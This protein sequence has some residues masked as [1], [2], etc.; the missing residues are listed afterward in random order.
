MRF[1]EFPD[2]SL[3][4]SFFP[5]SSCIWWRGRCY[6]RQ[7][8]RLWFIACIPTFDERSVRNAICFFKKANDSLDNSG[9]LCF[10]GSH[11]CLVSTLAFFSTFIFQIFYFHL[12]SLL[13]GDEIVLQRHQCYRFSNF[14]QVIYELNYSLYILHLFFVSHVSV[15]RF[16]AIKCTMQM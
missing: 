4:I 7:N 9:F 11:V 5:M 14:N 15:L 12:L 8:R 10:V 13:T 6:Y 2:I 16:S 1:A 3:A